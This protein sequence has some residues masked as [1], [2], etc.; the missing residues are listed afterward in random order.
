MVPGV[1]QQDNSADCYVD[2]GQLC[3]R[4]SNNYV[5]IEGRVSI[6]FDRLRLPLPLQLL[7]KAVG[8]LQN[9]VLSVFGLLAPVVQSA[10]GYAA[11][12]YASACV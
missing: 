6:P 5:Q 8:K 12:I 3:L 7:L 2:V 10:C 11:L 1:P 9:I 4:H